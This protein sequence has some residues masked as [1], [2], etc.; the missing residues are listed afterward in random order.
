MVLTS[1]YI[2]ISYCF[3]Y[4]FSLFSA[5]FPNYICYFSLNISLILVLVNYKLSLTYLKL[6]FRLDTNVMFSIGLKSKK[7]YNCKIIF[8]YIL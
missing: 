5:F 3:C 6:L 4:I 1:M 2:F 7:V 8:Y